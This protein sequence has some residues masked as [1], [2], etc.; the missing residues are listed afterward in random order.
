MDADYV[1]KPI[2]KSNNNPK[3]S[4]TNIRPKPVNPNCDTCSTIV[5][6]E[7]VSK[8]EMIEIENFLKQYQ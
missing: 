3:F 7:N 1:G 8:A 4:V 2:A 6:S 5:I